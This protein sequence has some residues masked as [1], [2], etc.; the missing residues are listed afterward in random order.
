M[1]CEDILFRNLPIK[2]LCKMEY[3]CFVLLRICDSLRVIEGSECYD[4]NGFYIFRLAN[5]LSALNIW[6]PC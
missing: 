6:N 5:P 1:V 4:L 3:F 2:H